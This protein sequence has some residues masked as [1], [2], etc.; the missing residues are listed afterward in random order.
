MQ[1]F[2]KS[3]REGKKK[4]SFPENSWKLQLSFWSLQ[5]APHI[6]SLVPTVPPGEAAVRMLNTEMGAEGL[7]AQR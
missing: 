2:E 1:Y 5:V 4:K 7:I 6:S 3:G